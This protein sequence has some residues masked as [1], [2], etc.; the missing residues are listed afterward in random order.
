ME[1]T[2]LGGGCRNKNREKRVEEARAV[3]ER[4]KEEAEE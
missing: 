2:W 3:E 1:G 4:G